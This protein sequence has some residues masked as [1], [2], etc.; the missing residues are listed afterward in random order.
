MSRRNNEKLVFFSKVS[1][2]LKLRFNGII[3]SENLKNHAPLIGSQLMAF[4][5]IAT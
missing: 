1:V 3:L 5:W 4:Y 2:Y